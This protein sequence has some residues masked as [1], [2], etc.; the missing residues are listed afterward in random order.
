MKIRKIAIEF[1]ESRQMLVA[2]PLTDLWMETACTDSAGP[3]AAE[4]EPQYRVNQ[5]PRVQLGNAPLKG[6][7]AFDGRDQI[8]I[9]WQTVAAGNGRDDS[10]L[11]EIRD[12]GSPN[13]PWRPS[14][15][16]QRI[17]TSIETRVIHSAVFTG[18]QWNHRYVYRVQHWRAGAIVNEY[19]STFETRLEPGDDASF[20][21]ATYGDSAV[22]GQAL[23]N[24]RKVQRAI[25]ASDADF[26]VL[27]GDNIYESGTHQEADIRFD[28]TLNPD[29]T[30]WNASSVD[31][32]GFGNHDSYADK[33]GSA[34]REN[35]AMPFPEAGV[36]AFVSPPAGEYAEF[37]SSFDYG[38]VHF[39]TFDSNSAEISRGEK[40]D[41]RIREQAEYLLANL[42]A[43][44]AEW[45][46]VYMHHPMLGSVKLQLYPDTNY[47]EILMP[48]LIEAGVDLIMTADS[49]TFA[50][51]YPVQGLNDTDGNNE[52]ADSEVMF[53]GRSKFDF[54]KGSGP[55][56]LISGTG[57]RDLRNDPFKQP[58]MAQAHSL[59]PARFPVESGFARVN[60][61]R[62][63]LSVQY[64]SAET[65][66][67]VGD[68]NQ[69]GARDAGEEYFAEF[70]IVDRSPNPD[71][72]AD[73]KVNSLD[74]NRICS[75]LLAAES[76]ARFDLNEDG[77]VNRVDHQFL[78][79]S[80]L[81]TT[82][83]D[84]NLDGVVNSSDLVLGPAHK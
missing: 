22:P 52:I 83:G 14:Q 17:D 70:N 64:I 20:S 13:G 74:I 50:W 69:N 9:L 66:R 30:Q 7:P 35:Y 62:R 25:T 37:S 63:R 24:F 77:Q 19:S 1:L 3:I 18:L 26:A 31:Y 56:Q 41:T 6:T 45:K 36:N 54:T 2:D 8:E 72:N 23:Q 38:N 67:I 44:D 40:R 78:V 21:F 11:A 71:L 55:V 28:P 42:A 84:A 68:L 58:V 80:V 57:G 33:I 75:A 32:L 81:K 61:D 5:T 12:A 46:I 39:V 51:T 47:L 29:A 60:V 53:D 82:A 4:A 73:G 15:P 16:L 59:D 79:S 43:S 27:L 49:H 76:D 34:T 10:F 48:K 65:G